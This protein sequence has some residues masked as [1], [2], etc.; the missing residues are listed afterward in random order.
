MNKKFC[1]LLFPL[2]LILS[3]HVLG[4]EPDSSQ[5]GSQSPH[6]PTAAELHQSDAKA[7]NK[8]KQ[9]KIRKKSKDAEAPPT[10]V[11]PQ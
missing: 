11:V 8:N 5:G 10:I 7:D 4:A 2:A 6:Q 1:V 3:S 9:M